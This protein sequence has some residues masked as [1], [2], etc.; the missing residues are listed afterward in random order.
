[1]NNENIKET[2]DYVIA[3]L[4]DAESRTDVNQAIIEL[5]KLSEGIV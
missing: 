3:L 2:L 1:M 4:E 5:E